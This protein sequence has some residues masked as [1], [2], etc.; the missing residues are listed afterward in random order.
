MLSSG[1]RTMVSCL[2]SGWLPSVGFW[3]SYRLSN[4]LAGCSPGLSLGM[5]LVELRDFRTGQGQ[6]Y[7][8]KGAGTCNEP[9]LDNT[10]DCVQGEIPDDQRLSRDQGPPSREERGG[11]APR[12]E[13][14]ER[15]CRCLGD[16][17]QQHREQSLVWESSKGQQWLAV[18]CSP[19][20]CLVY[21]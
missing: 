17:T 18:F 11:K 8:H 9:P 2:L 13:G 5:P 10:L 6:S 20:V 21:G 1:N 4:A 12:R 14:N 15:G 3:L 19:W 7:N 16:V